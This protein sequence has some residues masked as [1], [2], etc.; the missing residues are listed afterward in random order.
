MT[1]S[2]R[3]VLAGALLATTVA[4]TGCAAQ[5][6]P[7]TARPPTPPALLPDPR[8]ACFNKSTLQDPEIEACVGRLLCRWEFPKPLGGGIVLVTYP[9]NFT[10]WDPATDI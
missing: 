9:F 1:L 2:L 10:L 6:R 7:T 5:P 3:G 8:D 4:F